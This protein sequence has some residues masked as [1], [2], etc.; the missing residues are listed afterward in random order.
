MFG[1]TRIA[2]VAATLLFA[3][4]LALAQ[5][6]TTPRAEGAQRAETAPGVTRAVG[7]SDDSTPDK[8]KVIDESKPETARDDQAN[9]PETATD[10]PPA[11]DKKKASDPAKCCVQSN[12]PP[13][14]KP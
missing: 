8:S 4:S 3:G 10:D 7:P 2:S 11:A 5:S 14:Q 1:I 6:S 9:A 12:T 13:P